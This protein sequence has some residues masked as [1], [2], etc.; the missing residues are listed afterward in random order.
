[1]GW[2]PFL[3]KLQ[4]LDNLW[5]KAIPKP[6]SL[7][8][9]QETATSLVNM[10]QTLLTNGD[11]SCELLDALAGG[12]AEILN[13]IIRHFPE[14]IFWDFNYLVFHLLNLGDSDHLKET[15]ALISALHVGFGQYSSI[16]FRYVHDFLYGFDW[17]RWVKKDPDKRSHI[18]PYDLVFLNYLKKRQSELTQLIAADDVTYHRINDGS[19]RNPFGFSREP[20]SE[21][22]LHRSLAR[23]DLIPVKA[24]AYDSHP[25]WQKEYSKLRA[26]LAKQQAS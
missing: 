4:A 12:M 5:L 21:I 25:E 18:K 23:Q 9:L 19:F 11:W 2:N 6:L 26:Q 15:C 24:W 3:I 16:N 10:G 22:T 1:M 8:P 13:A 20:Q 7:S 17:E 14:N